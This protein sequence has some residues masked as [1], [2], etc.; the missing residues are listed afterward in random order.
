MIQ[1]VLNRK[2]Y[3]AGKKIFSEG[4]AGDRAFLVQSGAVEIFKETRDGIELLGRIAPGGIFGEMALLD[5]RPRMATARAAEDTVCVVIP[6]AVFEKKIAAADPF[7]VAL[8]RI[9]MA[10]VRTLASH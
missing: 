3:P 2:L 9:F 5:N 8:L 7:I 6:Q 4:E 1:D 10:N